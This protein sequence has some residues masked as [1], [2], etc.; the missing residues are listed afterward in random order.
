MSHLWIISHAISM[1]PIGGVVK[2][3]GGLSK[4]GITHC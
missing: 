2:Y 4:Q 3:T 1:I